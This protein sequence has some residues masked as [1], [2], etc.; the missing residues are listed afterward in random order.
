MKI[1]PEQFE[2]LVEAGATAAC[3]LIRDRHDLPSLHVPISQ[4]KDGERWLAETRA[5]LA[6]ILPLH[7][8]MV[9]EECAKHLETSGLY[10]TANHTRAL[11]TQETKP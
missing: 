5:A 3:D 7:R 10:S 1:T 4:I 9:I 11:A 6:A 8:A 2:T